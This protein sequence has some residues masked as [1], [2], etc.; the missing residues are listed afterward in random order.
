MFKDPAENWHIEIAQ[1][2]WLGGYTADDDEIA[3]LGRSYFGSKSV[4]SKQSPTTTET[5]ATTTTKNTQT[6]QTTML[7]KNR[8]NTESFSNGWN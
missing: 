7:A 8:L 3:K 4:N 5:E 1:L 2:Q 6:N